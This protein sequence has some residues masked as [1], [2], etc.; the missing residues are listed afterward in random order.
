MN[1]QKILDDLLKIFDEQIEAEKESR[2][3]K[4]KDSMSQGEV[5]DWHYD[6]GRVDGVDT[7]RFLVEEYFQGLEEQPNE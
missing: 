7:G 6:D 2:S 5:S 1:K 4:D 3:E